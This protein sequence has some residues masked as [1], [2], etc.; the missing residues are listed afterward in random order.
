MTN[1][2]QN[3]ESYIPQKIVYIWYVL[4]KQV[5]SIQSA[6]ILYGIIIGI[7]NCLITEVSLIQG[8][9]GTTVF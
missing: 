3:I 1:Y 4:I 5:S 7:D 9:Y 6:I 2:P 8:V